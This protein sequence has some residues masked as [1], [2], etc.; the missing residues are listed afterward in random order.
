[1]GTFF[2]VFQPCM[3]NIFGAIIFMRLTW[4]VG[5]TGWFGTV[6]MLLLG[7]LTVTLTT[8]SIAAISTNGHMGGGGAYFMISRSL[9]PELGGAVGIAY[10]LACS[11]GVTFYLIAF[12]NNVTSTFYPHLDETKASE[13]SVIIG[14]IALWVLVS[15]VVEPLFRSIHFH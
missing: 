11:I 6:L 5:Q 1:M 12:A 13:T 2:G 3:L 14:T 15:L 9:G 4:A 8:L 10:Y 7:A